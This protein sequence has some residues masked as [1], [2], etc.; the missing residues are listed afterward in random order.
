[1]FTTNQAVSDLEDALTT[2]G[3]L[4][5]ITGESLAVTYADATKAGV[6]LGTAGTPVTV[7]NTAAGAVSATSTDTVNGAQL[8]ATNQAVSDANEAISDLKDALD[9]GGVLDPTTGESLAVTYVNAAKTGIALG[10]AGTP[11]MVSNVAAGSVSAT[12]TEIVNGAQ[13]FATNQTVSDLKDELENSGLLDPTTGESLAVTYDST[14]KAG[15]TLGGTGAASPVILHN[16]D[17]GVADTDGVNV[18]QLTGG[19]TELKE[20]LING[21]I[22]L[23]Y[24]KVSSTGTQ[25]NAA[26][27]NSVAIGSSANASVNGSVAIGTGARASNTNAVA[28]GMNSVAN[29]PN[30]LSVG[31]PGNE[32]RIVNVADGE[33]IDGSTDA[34][35]GGQLNALRKALSAI[36]GANGAKDMSVQDAADPV[37]AIEGKSG[38]NIA[39][40]NDGDPEEAT[41]AAIGV[42]SV[43]SGSNAIAVGLHSQA[44][45]DYSVALGLMC[46]T[47]ADHEYSVAVG[48]DVHTNAERAVAFGIRVQAND[49]HALAIGSNETWATGKS[50]IAMG[51][52]VKVRG[53]HS[54][55]IG[56]SAMVALNVTDALA[57]GSG[58][59]VAA[60][61]IGGVALGHGAVANRG[62]AI[63]IGGG[64]VGARQI[65]HVRAGTEPTDAVNLAQ[66]TDVVAKLSAEIQLLRS[67]LGQRAA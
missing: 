42:F 5:P 9:N 51:D 60:E 35:N 13:L 36:S 4:D 48:S 62:N 28:V 50:S 2:G 38:N 29:L 46:Q 52:G 55:A 54:I 21:A 34:V 59:S 64:S 57:L 3:V 32:R 1:L 58:A 53:N 33:I 56:K 43:A 27:N 49:V 66:L 41:A 18:A 24:I 44:S 19:L 45:S 10:T 30:V 14:A 15:V 39:S 26:G 20:E 7:S 31:S 17:T 37:A 47:G 61:A 25:A 12:S 67:Q 16:M 63:S 22:D 6:V 40:L 8:F 11:V 65:I 23:K